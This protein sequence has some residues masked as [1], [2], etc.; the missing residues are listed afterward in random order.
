MGKCHGFMLLICCLFLAGCGGSS[1]SVTVPGTKSE[2]TITFEALAERE[3]VEGETLALAA[4][5]SSGLTVTFSSSDESV[6][7]VEGSTVTITGS[8]ET[9]ITA[10]QSGDEEYLAAESVS[11]SLRV[12]HLVDTGLGRSLWAGESTSLAG[13]VQ[14][15]KDS[16]TY[17]WEV[18]DQPGGADPVLGSPTA[19][20]TTFTPDVSGGYTL[21]LTVTDEGNS[22]THTVALAADRS[23][24]Q[25]GDDPITEGVARYP[26]IAA[27]PEGVPHLAAGDL[28][29][30]NKGV[31]RAFDPSTG[32]WEP[33][34]DPTDPDYPAMTASESR[35]NSL[36]FLPDN[37]PYL[38]ST[39]F[40]GS[41]KG[42]LMRFSGGAWEELG[43]PAGFSESATDISLAF[44]PESIPYVA[45]MNWAEGGKASVKRF[46]N[47]IWEN[48]GGAVVDNEVID[49]DS[50]SFAIS[51]DGVLHVAF[52]ADADN[53]III[54][55]FLQGSWQPLGDSGFGGGEGYQTSLAFSPDGIVHVGYGDLSAGGGVTVMR[56]LD[57][58]WQ[59]LG[60]PA[61]GDEDAWD[62]F[63]AISPDGTPFTAYRKGFGDF[64]RVLRFQ[65]G[66]WITEGYFP[67]DFSTHNLAGDISLCF[68]PDSTPYFSFR[69]N[70]LGT[71]N[72]AYARKV[73]TDLSPQVLRITPGRNAVVSEARPAIS[74]GFTLDIDPD[75]V[76]TD[77]FLVEDDLGPVSGGYGYNQISRTIT[78]TPARDLQG[79][80]AVELTRGI[81]STDG[82]AIYS[83]TPWRFNLAD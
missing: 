51:P 46:H 35:Y 16:Y 52:A 55:R 37:T 83:N 67:P 3:Y 64:P 27:N 8:G 68:G 69:D 82:Y 70:T 58:D 6:A 5:T 33:V 22:R 40:A 32:E 63:F 76:D 80:V 36:A 75:S 73:V 57:G 44:C 79:T 45:F 42:T 78:F 43:G 77:T 39:V 25:V 62:I 50:L 19:L 23:W 24:Q 4:S 28:E 66:Q 49:E 20:A 54:K 48:V 12:H 29:Y 61:S 21:R 74:A 53:T 56:F 2:Q 1:G 9:T 59:P 41:W 26:F 10:S 13:T 72:K 60:D 17:L 71:N 14:P 47:D 11:R 31:V 65:D 15:E 38:A 34:G 30:V 18:V 81:T 7:S